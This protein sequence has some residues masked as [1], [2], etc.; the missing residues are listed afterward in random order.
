M[1][2]FGPTGARSPLRDRVVQRVGAALLAVTALLSLPSSAAEY[3]VGRGDTLHVQVYEEPSLSGEVVV[4]DACAVSLGLV[5][6]VDVCGRTISEIESDI[7]ARYDGTYLVQP[8]VAVKVVRFHSQRVDLLGEVAR[9]GPQY[10]EGPTTL[11]EVL[12]L[13]G[14]PRAENV[15]RVTIVHADGSESAYDLTALPVGEPVVVEDGDQV[16]LLPGDVVYLEGEINKPGVVTLSSGLTVTQAL[17]LAGGPT[18]Y[19]GLR[20]VQVNRPDGSKVRVN[21]ARVHRGDETDLPLSADDHVIV[22]R[23]AF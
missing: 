10:L 11:V 15:V 19:A 8:T 18:E 14:G 2:N 1:N 6:R 20:R 12:S 5:G 3:R 17:A 13:A 16:F 23:S 4:S 22:P 7:V 21:V 9:P